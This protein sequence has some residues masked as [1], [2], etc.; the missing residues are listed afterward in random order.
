VIKK[1]ATWALIA[2]LVIWLINDP[3]G[4]AALA[5]N[6]AHALSRAASALTSITSSFGG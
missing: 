3:T 1:A 6:A 2:V 5:H 4:A